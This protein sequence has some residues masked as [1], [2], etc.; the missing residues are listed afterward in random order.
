MK[1]SFLKYPY[2]LMNFNR[3]DVNNSVPSI[4]FDA[5]IVPP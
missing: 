2:K 1:F 4:P 3:D 5:L